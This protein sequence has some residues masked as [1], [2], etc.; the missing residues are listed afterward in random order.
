MPA[1]LDYWYESKDGLQLY[2]REYPH[3]APAATIIC[4]PGLTRNSADFSDFCDQLNSD[5]RIFAVDLRG[6][7]KSAYDL[8]P[9]NYHPGIYMQDIQQLLE[10]L[11]LEKVILIGTSLGG[12]VSMFVTAINPDSVSALIIN[13]IGPEI[14]TTGLERIK[15]Y[16]TQQYDSVDSWDDAVSR[17]KQ[18]LK[19]EYPNFSEEDWQ[20]FA[21]RLYKEHDGNVCLDYDPAIAVLFEDEQT[22]NVPPDMWPMFSALTTVPMMVVR[23]E[24]SDILLP[25][26]ISKMQ[27]IHPHLSVVEVP[28]VGHA[29][30]L[31]DLRISD[32]AEK[33]LE[34]VLSPAL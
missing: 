5:Y 4:I 23:G 20:S 24:L 18:A 6:R 33:F 17:T 13:D 8:D 30:L 25:G 21:R 22:D 14:N 2:A 15:Y 28:E 27:D 12:L 9:K 19:R 10:K 16:I 7:G 31:E 26:T 29:P 34:T 11:D 1:Y 32:Q 3:E